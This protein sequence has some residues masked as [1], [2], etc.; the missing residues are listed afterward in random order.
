MRLFERVAS[1]K[2]SFIETFLLWAG[3]H[4]TLTIKPYGH[5]RPSCEVV[6]SW[7]LDVRN[8]NH[9]KSTNHNLHSTSKSWSDLLCC[10]IFVAPKESAR[11]SV[12]PPQSSTSPSK[13]YPINRQVWWISELIAELPISYAHQLCPPVLFATHQWSIKWSAA[14][15]KV[16]SLRFECLKTWTSGASLDSAPPQTV[17]HRK[18]SLESI[19]NSK[20]FRIWFVL[21]FWL[22]L[23]TLICRAPLPFKRIS[24]LFAL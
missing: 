6:Q 19:L 12:R 17:K 23:P 9:F 11:W 18:R 15:V 24:F 21:P 20:T 10:S 16:D 5:Q 13:A 1:K 14:R 2:E 3:S 4:P 8:L 22:S 7:K